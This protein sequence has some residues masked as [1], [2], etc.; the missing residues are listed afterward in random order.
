MNRW[1]SN[2][3]SFINRIMVVASVAR[4][5]IESRAHGSPE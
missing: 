5:W 4:M 3:N 2:L 1:I